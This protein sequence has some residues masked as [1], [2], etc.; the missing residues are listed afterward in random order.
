MNVLIDKKTEY[1]FLIRQT[2]FGKGVYLHQNNIETK[3][4]ID[5]I[6]NFHAD[7]GIINFTLINDVSQKKTTMFK[8]CHYHFLFHS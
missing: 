8:I 7:N 4:P 5:L 6:I 3:I 1:K 2:Q